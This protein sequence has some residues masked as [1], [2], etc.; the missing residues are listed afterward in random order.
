MNNLNLKNNQP[1]F[2][3][4]V[5]LILMLVMTTMGIGLYYSSKQAAKEV[6][7]NVDKRSYIFNA[8][9]CL[10][11]AIHWLE[12]NYNSCSIGSICK[13]IETNNGMNKWDIGEENKRKKQMESQ[14]YKCQIQKMKVKDLNDGDDGGEGFDVGQG[15]NYESEDTIKQHYFKI[16]SNGFDVGGNDKTSIEVILSIIL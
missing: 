14:G 6:L 16:N 3:I 12:I 9:S 2:I 13:T 4:V 11:E 5:T 8:E 1:G 7:S 10:T 15:D